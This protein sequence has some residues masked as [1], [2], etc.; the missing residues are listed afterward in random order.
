MELMEESKHVKE[1]QRPPIHHDPR[2]YYNLMPETTRTPKRLDPEQEK[3]LNEELI[4]KSKERE[5]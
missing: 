1:E 4:H 3:R 2:S 5:K